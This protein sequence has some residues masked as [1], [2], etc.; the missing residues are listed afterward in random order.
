MWPVPNGGQSSCYP[1]NW[2]NISWSHR[3]PNH[4]LWTILCVCVCV[5][6]II[7]SFDVRNPIKK[8]YIETKYKIQV[9]SSF[10]RQ[11]FV[12]WKRRQ[13]STERLVGRSTNRI[14]TTFSKHMSIRKLTKRYYHFI[15]HRY[16]RTAFTR[17]NTGVVGSNSTRGMDVCVRLF[18]ICAVLCVGSGLATGCSPVQGVLPTVCGLRNWKSGQGPQEL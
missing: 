3:L 13:L 8:L 10:S 7:F 12:S 16:V 17:S 6:K 15:V 18:C 4:K 1:E 2:P 5:C 11:L 9:T 14:S